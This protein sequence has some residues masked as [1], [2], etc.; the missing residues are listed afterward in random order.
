MQTRNR[1]PSSKT[2]AYREKNEALLMNSKSCRDGG[3]YVSP[4]VPVNLMAI[5]VSVHILL[6]H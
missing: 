1:Q 4:G 3:R 6:V 2:Q 5:C